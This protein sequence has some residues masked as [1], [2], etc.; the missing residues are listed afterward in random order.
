M[1]PDAAALVAAY[2]ERRATPA[3]VVERCLVAA[4]DAAS[5]SPSHAA[6]RVIDE[7]GA[8]E[9]ARASTERWARGEP[10]GP[11]DGVPVGVKDEVDVEGL[12]TR[13]GTAFMPD[14]PARHDATVV[15]RLRAAGAVIVG[16]TAQHELGIG[17]TGISPHDALTPRNPHRPTHAPGGSSSGSAVAVALGLVPLAVGTDAGGSIRIPSALCGVFGLKPTWGRVPNTG[18]A[19]LGGTLG[20]VGPLARSTADLATFLSVASGDDGRDPIARGA[21]KL[22]PEALSAALAEGARGLH[23]GVDELEWSAADPAVA[24]AGREA[25]RALEKE[26][27][28][29]RAVHVPLAR[30]APAMGFVVMLGEAAATH[31]VDYERHRDRM[32]YDVRMA[33]AVGRRMRAG[34]L[35]HA[36]IL[37]QR[38]RRQM[39]AAFA[40]VDLVATPTTAM[41]APPV[42][43]GAERT[44]E[45]DQPTTNGLVRY[46]Y[47]GNLTGLP[48][49]TAPVGVD[50]SGLPIGLQLYARA[51]DEA[52][53]LRALA[54]LERAGVATAPRPAVGFEIL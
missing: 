41:T 20:H 38:L 37:R 9:A 14:A 36:Q 17:A 52:M 29:V 44:G 47:L 54:A 2:R 46:T 4:R 7:R 24:S 8:R 12:A 1:T 42:R 40:H 30:H 49:A 16:K 31:A 5:K 27:A 45:A 32:G 48:A 26:G 51:W 25:L 11:L 3:E 39:N 21:S 35:T 19:N 13:S 53:A 28:V 33:L 43:P 34:E 15:A 18:D 6:F 23:I 22:S 50:G 10:S